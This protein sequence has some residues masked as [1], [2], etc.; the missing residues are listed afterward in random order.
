MDNILLISLILI[1]IVII[2][3]YFTYC[4]VI[5]QKEHFDGNY[6][7]EN[8][9]IGSGDF[10]ATA[11]A[12]LNNVYKSDGESNDMNKNRIIDGSGS[13]EY[14]DITYS[15]S[16]YTEIPTVQFIGQC[17]QQAKALAIID[18][19]RVVGILL[20][21]GGKGYKTNPKVVISPPKS[22]NTNIKT[23]TESD[24]LNSIL[25]GI[26]S[27]ENSFSKQ[28]DAT[29]TASM[30]LAMSMSEG[31][32]DST[33]IKNLT[34]AQIEEKAKEYE[35]IM[36]ENAKQ[37]AKTQ[38][39]AKAK[40]LDVIEYQAKEK[41]ATAY[42]KKYGLPPPPQKYTPAEIT[43]IKSD[44][45]ASNPRILS[46]DQKAQCMLLLND[47]TQKNERV[48]DLGNLSANQPYMIPQVKKAST[49]AQQAQQLYTKTCQ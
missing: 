6:K 31:N 5:G 32:T 27:I 45:K 33:S 1:L 13:V 20:L 23:E 37:T 38:A 28:S 12:R 43:Q 49:V 2:L 44:A 16:N 18:T 29:T 7:N 15:G 41:S 11:I 10:T 25:T 35:D 22:V 34:P 40:L 9:N 26:K 4:G 17:K 48:Q 19:G 21:D 24:L 46:T 30:S 36:N 42:A 8:N 3:K 14:I 47:Y 39:E